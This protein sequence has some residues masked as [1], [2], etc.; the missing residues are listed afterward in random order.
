MRGCRWIIVPLV[1]LPLA[2]ALAGPVKA[3]ETGGEGTLRKC[4]SFFPTHFCRTYNHVKLPRRVAVGDT[5]WLIFGSNIKEFGF[6]VARIVVN[7]GHCTIY[8]EAGDDPDQDKLFVEPC[9]AATE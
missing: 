1:A 3:V 9:Q 5:V 8:S 7:R 6:S 4:P 2:S